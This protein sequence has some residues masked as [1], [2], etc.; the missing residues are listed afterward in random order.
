VAVAQG[1]ASHASV[2]MAKGAVE[3]LARSLAAE[4]AP[5]VRVNVVAPSLTRTPL[6]RA[7][8]ANEGM[9][10]GIAAMHALQRLGEAEDI[11]A[12]AAF[13]VSSESAWITGQ[14]LGVDGGRSTLR[15][16]G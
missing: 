2:G 11:A 7:L 8:T 15:T 1:F 10:S 16:K 5:K 12:A 6:A 9:A 14:V 4:L 3:G 13:L